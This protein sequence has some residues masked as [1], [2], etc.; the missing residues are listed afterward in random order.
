VRKSCIATIAF[1][2]TLGISG[3]A[4]A[5]GPVTVSAFQPV[6]GGTSCA[7]FQVTGS[8]Q[9]YALVVTDPGFN[10]QFGF[11]MSA[12]YSGT[13]VTFATSGT[14]CGSFPK[15]QWIYAGTAM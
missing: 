4:S 12:F 3:M 15:I 10:S 5:V 8:G 6:Q 13:P 7:F 9:W 2:V 14:A 11:V 1:L